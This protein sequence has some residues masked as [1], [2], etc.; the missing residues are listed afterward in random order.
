MRNAN[1]LREF[2]HDFGPGAHNLTVT[3]EAGSLCRWHDE[4]SCWYVC[5]G[6]V[7]IYAQHDANYRGIPVGTDN[8][9]IQGE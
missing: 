1:T 8:L 5:P 9:K 2:V 7:P 6:Q 4:N 3:V